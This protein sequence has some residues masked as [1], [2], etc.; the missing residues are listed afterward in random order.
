MYIASAFEQKTLVYGFS[1]GILV[2]II[3]ESEY[4]PELHKG[5]WSFRVKN[6]VDRRE[7]S[8]G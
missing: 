4:L 5:M 3:F 7:E 2:P 6:C 1:D 8:L